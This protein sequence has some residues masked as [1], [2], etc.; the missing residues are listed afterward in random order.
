MPLAGV[1]LKIRDSTLR[2]FKRGSSMESD[3]WICCNC[4]VITL[5]RNGRCPICR[6]DNVAPFYS[7]GR[8]E[9]AVHKVHVISHS[10]VPSQPERTRKAG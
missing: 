1:L 8:A 9:E 3:E 10:G 2:K 6:A 4:G 5:D 7:P